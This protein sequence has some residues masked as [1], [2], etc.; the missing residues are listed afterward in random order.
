MVYTNKIMDIE[1]PKFKC[2]RCGHE[3]HPRKQEYPK[4]CAKCKSP[5]W[6]RDRIKGGDNEKA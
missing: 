2:K 3:W 4:C 6:D 1:L 5:Y